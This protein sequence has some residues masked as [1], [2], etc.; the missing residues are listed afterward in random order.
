MIRACAKALLLLAV[1]TTA[2]AAEPPA[3]VKESN[4]HAKVALETLARFQPEGATQVGVEGFDGQVMDLKPKLYKRQ[5]R[6]IEEAIEELEQRLARA[7]DP[8]VR[9]DLEIMIR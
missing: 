4:E 7:T 9:Q 1:A 6:A 8:A 3:W 5:Q 2:T